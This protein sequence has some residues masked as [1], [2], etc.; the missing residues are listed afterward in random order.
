MLPANSTNVGSLISSSGHLMLGG[1]LTVAGNLTLTDTDLDVAL[2]YNGTNAGVDKHIRA[3]TI[4]LSGGTLNINDAAVDATKLVGN[5]TLSF[6]VMETVNGLTGQFANLKWLNSLFV[7]DQDTG[8]GKNLLVHLSYADTTPF[9][10]Y[11]INHNTREVTRV[12]NWGMQNEPGLI[13]GLVGLTDAEI[14][15]EIDRMRGSEMAAD[16]LK[17]SFWKPWKYAFRQAGVRQGNSPALS[18]RTNALAS[19]AGE[20]GTTRGWVN[21]LGSKT[22]VSSDGN[23]RKYE[24]ERRGMVLGV[25]HALNDR[26]ILGAQ[27][28]YLDHELDGKRGRRI[29]S[30]DI[31]VGMYAS[32]IPVEGFRADAYLGYGWQDH[33]YRRTDLM[34]RHDA[35]YDGKS[36]YASVQVSKPIGM[37]PGF[38]ISPIVGLDYQRAKNKGFTEKGTSGNQRI[39]SA[40]HDLLTARIGIS[41]QAQTEKARWNARLDYGHHLGGK[42]RPEITSRF[43]GSPGSPSMKLYGVETGRDYVE[44]GVGFEVFLDAKKKV[45]LFGDYDYHHASRE[46]VHSGRIG[47]SVKW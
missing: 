33:D 5:Q 4:V 10:R 9:S 25:D 12:L 19:G 35:D 23:A 47:L 15:G 44:A 34:G 17:L 2:G 29:D 31:S 27:L 43:V 26:T 11:G 24:V 46:K 3:D 32:T 13:Q 36:L 8:D 21:V 41:A 1:D 45:S 6:T 37:R 16:S 7:L 30:Q 18:H 40:D 22:D 20:S 38:T 28:A 39:E 42:N 14:R